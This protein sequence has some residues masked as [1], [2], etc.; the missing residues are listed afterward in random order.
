MRNREF[1][2]LVD[3]VFGPTYGRTLAAD[4]VLSAL[5]D[6]TVEQSIEDG[7]EPR[8]VWHALCDAMDVP[9]AQRWGHDV[10]RQAPPPR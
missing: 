6:R 3:E 4:Q 7:V 2:Q 9:D 5:G 10:N 1:W 8:E